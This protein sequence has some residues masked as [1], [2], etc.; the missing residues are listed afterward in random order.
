M[1]KLKS[2]KLTW[3]DKKGNVLA[4]KIYHFEHVKEAK[5]HAKTLLSECS[6]SDVVKIG[7]SRIR[8]DYSRV[9][10]RQ[11]RME[12]DNY[13]LFFLANGEITAIKGEDRYIARSITSLHKKL[14]G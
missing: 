6:N 5:F 3:E 9:I 12:K 13:K 11:E 4:S 14:Y 8:G 2:Y 1:R 7:V 10:A